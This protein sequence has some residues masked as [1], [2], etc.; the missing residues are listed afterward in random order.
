MASRNGRQR[1]ARLLQSHPGF[2]SKDLKVTAAWGQEIHEALERGILPAARFR[3]D[4]ETQR[5]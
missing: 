5:S 3:L 4:L 1:P 2:E